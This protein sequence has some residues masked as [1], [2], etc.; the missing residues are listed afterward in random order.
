MR[1]TRQSPRT[2]M[3]ITLR[4]P[5]KIIRENIFRY[6]PMGLAIKPAAQTMFFSLKNYTLRAPLVATKLRFSIW[7]W[8]PALRALD[9]HACTTKLRFSSRS[10]Y[11]VDLRYTA[12]IVQLELKTCTL[13][14]R[15]V[16][17]S[18]DFQAGDQNL[19]FAYYTCATKL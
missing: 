17:Q 1:K 13:R 16:L 5:K 6:K 3:H 18:C 4:K 8:T 9:L 11:F 2:R 14:T 19:Y 7:S 12:A 15:L 10:W